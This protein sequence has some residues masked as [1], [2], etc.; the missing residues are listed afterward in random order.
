MGQLDLENLVIGSYQLIPRQR[1][2]LKLPTLARV[3]DGGGQAAHVS[4]ASSRQ[5][6][7]SVENPKRTILG[8]YDAPAATVLVLHAYLSLTT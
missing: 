2:D 1:I 8:C 5:E 4:E 7:V 6:E 3:L